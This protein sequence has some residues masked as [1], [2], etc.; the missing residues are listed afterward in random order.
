MAEPVIGESADR[1]R[2]WPFSQSRRFSK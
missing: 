2:G 1:E